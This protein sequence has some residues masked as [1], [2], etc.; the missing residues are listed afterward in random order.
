MPAESPTIRIDH[1]MVRRQGS[2]EI[3]ET[4][5]VGRTPD[6]EGHYASDHL[7]VFVAVSIS[8]TT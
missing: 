8:G 5:L 2:A 6:A 1:V 4:Q 7:G 3:L